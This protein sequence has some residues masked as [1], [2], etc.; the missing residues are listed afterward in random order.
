LVEVVLERSGDLIAPVEVE[1]VM[2]DGST[3]RRTWDGLDTGV[4]WQIH[5]DQMVQRV[6]V[7]PE[8]VWVLESRRWDNYWQE[9][10]PRRRPWW[11]LGGALGLM[12]SAVLGWS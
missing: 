4:R 1:L 8:R 7:D 6:V 3:Q 9:R 11:W 10:R 2:A 5:A 12:Q